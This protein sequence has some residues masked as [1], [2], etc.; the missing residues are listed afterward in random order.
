[1][2]TLE[3]DYS[4]GL[5]APYWIQEIRLKGKVYW[6]FQT[7]ISVSF[8]GMFLL[9]EGLLFLIA[10]PFLFLFVHFTVV[11]MLWFTVLPFRLGRAY[12]EHTP[13]GKS[14]H[15]FVFGA[16]RYVKDFRW[17]KRGIYNEGRRMRGLTKVVF[18]KT[19]L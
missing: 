9:F 2:D 13:D 12:V 19:A 7:P 3:Y 18:E 17:N 15:A 8:V 4:L 10:L 1:M 6:T 11:P 16:L 14:V 5:N